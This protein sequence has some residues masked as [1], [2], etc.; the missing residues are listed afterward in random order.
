LWLEPGRRLTDLAAGWEGLWSLLVT[1]RQAALALVVLPGLDD[2]L[3]FTEAA[4]DLR[5]A[6]EELEWVQPG[7]PPRAVSVDLSDAPLH[8]VNACRTAVGRPAHRR[9]RRGGAAEPPAG[10][11]R[12]PS[13][14]GAVAGV[15]VG[16]ERA[17][18][19]GWAAAMSSR[20]RYRDLMDQAA[21]QIAH[22]STL[23]RTHP[24]PGSQGRSG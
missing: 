22:A 10:G 19:G 24:S 5:E 9:A 15:P 23:L 14:A 11:V 12:H 4:L 16:G 21:A 18:A 1:A 8:E 13:G 7:L 6:V 17:P 20:V 2:D 3:T